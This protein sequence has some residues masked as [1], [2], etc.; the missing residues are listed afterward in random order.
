MGLLNI[1]IHKAKF[2]NENGEYIKDIKIPKNEKTFEFN[3]GSYNVKRKDISYFEKKG[4][5]YNT[6]FYFYN[7]KNCDPFVLKSN[8]AIAL[9]PSMYNTM[10]K[11]KIAKDLND[12]N[13]KGIFDMFK[14][15]KILIGGLVVLIFIYLASTGQLQTLIRGG[16]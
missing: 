6:R 15:P 14:D 10:L 4:V 16:A 12:V 3:G 5:L 13:K 1:T 8:P 9:S 2:F 11:T 7:E